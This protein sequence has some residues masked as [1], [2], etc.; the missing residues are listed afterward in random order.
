MQIKLSKKKNDDEER[1]KVTGSRRKALLWIFPFFPIFSWFCGAARDVLSKVIRLHWFCSSWNSGWYYYSRL[2][3]QRRLVIR[4]I[5]KCPWSSKSEFPAASAVGSL[6]WKSP[7]KKNKCNSVSPSVRQSVRPSVRS[8]HKWSKKYS[9]EKMNRSKVVPNSPRVFPRNRCRPP[10]M[11][12]LPPNPQK[13][14]YF[15][16]ILTFEYLRR[17]YIFW[18]ST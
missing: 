12:P 10:L 9:D 17:Y 16:P 6:H 2:F 5:L 14:G 11:P 4:L 1:N 3:P 13:G 15:P 8:R 18:H 7:P